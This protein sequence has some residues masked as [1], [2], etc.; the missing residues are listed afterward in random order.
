M[1]TDPITIYY[2][3]DFDGMVSGALLAH[4]LRT[5]RGE[6]V[7]VASINYDRR[8]DWEQF[9]EGQRFAIVDFHFHPRAEIWFDHHATTFL[10]EELRA[11][12]EPSE[13]W[14]WDADS[15]SCPPLIIAHAKRHWDFEVP[16]RF[17]EMSKWSD[18]I[19]A[20]AFENVQQALF[21]EHPALRITRALTASPGPE[22]IDA[23]VESMSTQTLA[24]VAARTDVERTYQRACRNRDR[25]LE[26][27]P[28]TVEWRRDG[29]LVYDASSNK[30]R[31]DR[32]SPFYHNPK[33]HYAVGVIPTRAGFHVTC[34]QNPWHPPADP[35]HIGE[36]METYGGGGHRAVGGA[37]P[38]SLQAAR[39][40]AME[41]GETL[42]KHLA[43]KPPA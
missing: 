37:N 11:A 17:Q 42:V 39:T 19:D 12:Y 10:S 2:H 14:C 25:A 26:Q 34:G 43:T 21:G 30:I 29:V 23:L 35:Y 27:F 28:P 31:R 3:R 5:V 41:I 4:I 8:K 16:E 9:E 36:L 13:R 33:I 38:E 1:V 22:W 7:R 40:A 18:I 15:P 20:A 32:F 6:Q 24:E